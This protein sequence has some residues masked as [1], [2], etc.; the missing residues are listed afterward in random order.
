VAHRD[1]KAANDFFTVRHNLEVLAAG[2]AALERSDED[3]AELREC[4]QSARVMASEVFE[5]PGRPGQGARQFHRDTSVRFHELI[6][7]ASHN[8]TLRDLLHVL[9]KK[10]RWYFTPGVLG[11]TDR[12]WNEHEELLAAL[13]ARDAEAARALMDRHMDNTLAS[14]LD[15]ID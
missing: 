9:V 1:R 13:E 10:T 11:Q 8:D 2:Q 5:S 12:A 15:N 14:Y 3:L 4:I 7:Q 6:A